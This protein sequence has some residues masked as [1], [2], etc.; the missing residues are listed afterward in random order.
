MRI[1][2]LAGFSVRL[3]NDLTAFP[4]RLL[5]EIVYNNLNGSILALLIGIIGLVYATSKHFMMHITW[6]IFFRA[7]FS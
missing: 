4:H 3:I 1:N 2:C 5:V 6:R 7:Q